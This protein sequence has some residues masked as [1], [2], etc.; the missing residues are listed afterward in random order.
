MLL[1]TCLCAREIAK[2]CWDVYSI[3][4][5]PRIVPQARQRQ[6]QVFLN[7]IYWELLAITDMI[8][9]MIEIPS[10]PTLQDAFF[11]SPALILCACKIVKFA[12]ANNC[13]SQPQSDAMHNANIEQHTLDKASIFCSNSRAFPLNPPSTSRSDVWLHTKRKYSSTSSAFYSIS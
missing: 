13:I 11:Q 5:I 2:Y 4:S 9:D 7:R 6:C 8:A 3:S 10:Q 1:S 12:P